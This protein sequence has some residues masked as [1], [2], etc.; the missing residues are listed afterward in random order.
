MR[1]RVTGALVAATVCL[2]G[3]ALADSAGSG[4]LKV[5][6][7]PGIPV[8]I[9]D[10]ELTRRPSTAAV[11]LGLRMIVKNTASQPIR[12]LELHVEV[13]SPA[14]QLTGFYGFTIKAHVPPGEEQTLRYFTPQ[15][16]IEPGDLVTVTLGRA[17]GYSRVWSSES[18]DGSVTKAGPTDTCDAR[19]AA[20]EEVC[21]EKCTCGTSEFSCSCGVG[22]LSYSCKCF[23]CI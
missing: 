19:C 9:R 1:L 8:T 15:F 22:T 12:L 6:Q 5:G 11:P 18:A 17:E 14:G 20:K 16:E 23:R 4:A 21:S 3:H 10:A 7:A 2:T 13:T